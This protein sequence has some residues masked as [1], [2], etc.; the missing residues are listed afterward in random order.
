MVDAGTPGGCYTCKGLA[1]VRDLGQHLQREFFL[2]P[3]AGMRQRL[4]GKGGTGMGI[5]GGTVVQ[6]IDAV[7][8]AERL[9][10]ILGQARPDALGEFQAACEARSGKRDVVGSQR[11]A[12]HAKVE[13]GVVSDH[14]LALQVG[15]YAWPQLPEVRLVPHV[16]RRDAV[17]RHIE[18]VEVR[19]I[20]RLDQPRFRLHN[21]V[22]AHYCQA[23]LARA[24]ALRGSGLK[25]YRHKIHGLKLGINWQKE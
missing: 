25:I 15:L 8:V 5:G 2:G 16:C 4:E 17:H 24:V 6:E 19:V 14:E 11:F 23:N 10:V 20:Q 9:Q 21:L 18:G 7:H 1:K 13:A 22:V 3:G 12:Q